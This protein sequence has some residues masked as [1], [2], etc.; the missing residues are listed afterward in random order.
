MTRLWLAAGGGGDALAA[1]ILHRAVGE[2]QPATIATYAWDRLAVDPLPG[3]RA[4]ADFDGLQP[5]TA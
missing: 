4:A 2:S 1:S 5:S 3:P